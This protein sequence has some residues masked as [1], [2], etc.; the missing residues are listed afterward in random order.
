MQTANDARG[1]GVPGWG[2][3]FIS[4]PVMGAEVGVGRELSR[5][6]AEHREDW[7]RTRGVGRLVP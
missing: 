1:T 5:P 2:P 7:V 4:G 3:V 6:T